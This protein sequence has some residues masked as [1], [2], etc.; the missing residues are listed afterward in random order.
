MWGGRFFPIYDLRHT[1]YRLLPTVYHLPACGR[2][3]VGREVFP[4]LRP[5][6][7]HLPS[8]TY[9]TP[10]TRILFLFPTYDLPPTNYLSFQQHSR[11]QS[12]TTFVFCNIPAL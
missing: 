11:F 8:T 2:W 12:V 10:D 1:T 7:Y 6:T 4:H 3:Y 9:Q 5:T